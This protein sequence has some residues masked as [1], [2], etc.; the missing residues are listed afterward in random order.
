MT[1]GLIITLTDSGLLMFNRSAA[2]EASCSFLI[3][4]ITALP[5]TGWFTRSQWLAIFGQTSAWSRKMDGFFPPLIY[6]FCRPSSPKGIKAEKVTWIFVPR[7][8]SGQN[9]LGCFYIDS[10]IY[11]IIAVEHLLLCSCLRPCRSMAG[12]SRWNPWSHRAYILQG[13]T[14][15]KSKDKWTWECM[16]L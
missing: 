12:Q 15:S 6:F 8:S 5:F 14:E 13:E 2:Q 1:L 7:K 16:I 11:S 10:T 9:N 3:P 4:C